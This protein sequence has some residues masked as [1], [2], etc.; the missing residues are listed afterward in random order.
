MSARQDECILRVVVDHMYSPPVRFRR[1]P[2]MR[3]QALEDSL[4]HSVQG[5]VLRQDF[6]PVFGKDLAV[7]GIGGRAHIL[8]GYEVEAATSG[9]LV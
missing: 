8:V 6:A 4:Y 7:C 5:M 9:D 2:G 3:N 1:Q